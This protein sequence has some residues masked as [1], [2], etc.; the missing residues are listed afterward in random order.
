MVFV[1]WVIVV[2]VHYFPRI[3]YAFVERLGYWLGDPTGLTILRCPICVYYSRIHV[4][5]RWNVI[6]RDELVPEV[7]KVGVV[8]GF[9]KSQFCSFDG[10]V[11]RGYTVSEQ[12]KRAELSFNDVNVGLAGQLGEQFSSEE[13]GRT[14][15]DYSK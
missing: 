15:P 12:S 7:L 13:S 9:G 11:V 3:F 1:L 14:S 8:G 4:F 5:Q 10:N 6:F 2:P